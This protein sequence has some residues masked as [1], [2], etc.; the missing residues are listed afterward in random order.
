[1]PV[2]KTIQTGASSRTTHEVYMLEVC[3]HSLLSSEDEHQLAVRYH[4]RRDLEAAR[5]LITANLR[6][7]V[8]MAHEYK[9][10]H[11]DLCDLVQEGNLGLVR[12]VESY[13]PHR[14]VKL[15]SYARWWIRAYML[16]FILENWRLVKLGTTQAQR[17][18]FFNLSKE[19]RKL[20]LAGLPATDSMVAERL[21]VPEGTVTEMRQR[22]G[23]SEVPLDAPE[24]GGD[25]QDLADVL[26]A[27]GEERPDVQAERREQQRSWR[28][29]LDRYRQTL[30]GMARTIFDERLLAEEPLTLQAIADRHGVSRERARQVEARVMAHLRRSVLRSQRRPSAVRPLARDAAMMA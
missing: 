17:K 30:H 10:M 26:E 1:M 11:P 18:L 13:N 27:G 3:H 19:R 20:E 16:R 24:G 9:Q 23:A 22:L 4:G 7:A 28:Q 14:S 5:R 6:L 12:A 2:H 21:G 29:Q 15:S 25:G 8:K